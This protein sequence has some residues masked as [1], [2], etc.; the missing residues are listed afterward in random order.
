MKRNK[1][2]K[3][4]AI[5]RMNL[6]KSGEKIFSLLTIRPTMVDD[7]L[8]NGQHKSISRK[9]NISSS[10][11]PS[12]ESYPILPSIANIDRAP[13]THSTASTQVSLSPMQSSPI[14]PQNKHDANKERNN[15]YKES[16]S[17]PVAY[18][19]SIL[20]LPIASAC[21]EVCRAIMGHA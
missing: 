11:H 18:S 10:F 17:G 1:N 15:R 5:L 2:A 19:P 21:P 4:R 16:S 20:P 13:S 8:T 12:S 14:H 9:N 7:Q 3:S 6:T